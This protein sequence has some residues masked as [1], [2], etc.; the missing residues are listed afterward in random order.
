[1]LANTQCEKAGRE[2]HEFLGTFGFGLLWKFI[3]FSAAQIL[4]EIIFFFFEN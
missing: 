4:R 2:K 3:N 1:M